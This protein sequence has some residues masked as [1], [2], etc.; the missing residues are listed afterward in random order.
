[1]KLYLSNSI[2]SIDKRTQAVCK[3]DSIQLVF[4]DGTELY[5]EPKTEDDLKSDFLAIQTALKSKDKK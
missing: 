1:M 3:G 4:W 5:L 2:V